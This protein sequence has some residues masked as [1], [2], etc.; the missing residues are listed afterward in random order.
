MEKGLRR[1]Q[2]SSQ[3]TA[4]SLSQVDVH[5][6]G[7]GGDLGHASGQAVDVDLVVVAAGHARGP[8]LLEGT[9]FRGLGLDDQAGGA[10]LGE[11]VA[12]RQLPR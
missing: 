1:F 11:L 8:F 7:Q 5:G 10:D 4:R 3:S 6:R 12:D 9:E 2:P